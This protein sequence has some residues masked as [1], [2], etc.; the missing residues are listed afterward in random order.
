[1][2]IKSLEF[3]LLDLVN[4]QQF[5]KA[6]K[7]LDAYP[8]LITTPTF[9]TASCISMLLLISESYDE[10]IQFSEHHLKRLP[11]CDLHYNLAYAYENQGDSLLAIKNYQC[12]RLFTL[13]LDFR[14]EL[15]EK[16]VRLRFD[17]QDEEIINALFEYYAQEKSYVKEQLLHPHQNLNPKDYIHTKFPISAYQPS[18]LYGTMEIANHI[19]HYIKV[20]RNRNFIVLGIDYA[21]NYLQY[22]LD[23]SQSFD[24]IAGDKAQELRLLNTIDLISDFDVFH[25]VFNMTLM[26][27]NLD[28]H[29]LKKLGKK[30]FMHNLGSEIR[31][32]SIARNHHPYWQYAEDYLSMLNED[33]IKQNI[34]TFS[35]WVDHCIIND[36]EMKSYVQA[37]YKHVHMLGLPINLEKY[38]YKPQVK[39]DT[40]HVVHA[41]TNRSVKGSKY[42]EAALK[43][44]SE[45][46]PIHYTRVEK[47]DHDEA[48]KIYREADIV[49]DELII[50]TYGSLTIECMAMGPCVATF[51]NPSFNTP[52]NEEIPVWSVNVDNLVQ[53]LD[54]LMSSFELR[55]ELSL[56]ARSYVERNNDVNIIGAKLLEIYKKS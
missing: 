30:V 2:D 40:I 14:N 19:S 37:D 4:Q 28:L 43:Q 9:E 45:K 39:R 22:D 6:L 24:Q 25:F 8:E 31:V 3:S 20:F 46:Y 23:F 35:T 10:C 48:M 11:I 36:Y 38:Q 34:H 26:S 27:G 16:I 7:L 44:L 55:N 50:G 53:R 51:I 17:D 54:E 42:F 29:P 12:A 49:L 18:I 47:M 33:V 32:P 56:R 5:E 1:M 15:N 41:P 13:D 52:H 21:P